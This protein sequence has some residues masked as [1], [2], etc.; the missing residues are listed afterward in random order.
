MSGT[1]SKPKNRGERI[2]KRRGLDELLK[3]LPSSSW[4]LKLGRGS[5]AGKS[6]AAWVKPPSR[7]AYSWATFSFNKLLIS[8]PCKQWLAVKMIS[9]EKAS[10]R[11]EKR[12]GKKC[13]WRC[14]LGKMLHFTDYHLFK[15]CR[16]EK[17][18]T[19]IHTL[20]VFNRVLACSPRKRKN[21]I[22]NFCGF[23]QVFQWVAF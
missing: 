11:S 23:N 9:S 17:Q 6:H 16:R 22:L 5:Q 3:L 20:T 14:T 13:Y 12:C 7:S 21:L 10:K 18:T 2:Q 15:S 4:Y 8:F 1:A 19:T